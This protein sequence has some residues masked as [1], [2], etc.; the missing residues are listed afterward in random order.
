[1][2]HGKLTSHNQKGR[3]DA[4]VE[5]TFKGLSICLP[6]TKA[7]QATATAEITYGQGCLLAADWSRPALRFV[8][9]YLLPIDRRCEG[10]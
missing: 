6:K 8:T 7:V 1:M 9:V 5:M 4:N 10:G 3:G 2:A